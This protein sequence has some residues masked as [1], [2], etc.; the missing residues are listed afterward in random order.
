MVGFEQVGGG[1]G[2]TRG[3][4]GEAQGVTCLLGGGGGR[5][6]ANLQPFATA[7]KI[8]QTGMLN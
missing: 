5:R 7:L 6:K 2:V 8:P 4:R 3:V 1:G